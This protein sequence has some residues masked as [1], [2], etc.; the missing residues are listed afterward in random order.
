M[1][2]GTASVSVFVYSLKATSTSVFY[3]SSAD[4]CAMSISDDLDYVHVPRLSHVRPLM[5]C[6][7]ELSLVL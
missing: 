6:F 3:F 4:S 1:L 2:E 7:P 5:Y